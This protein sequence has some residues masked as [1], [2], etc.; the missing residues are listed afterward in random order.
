SHDAGCCQLNSDCPADK[1][2]CRACVGCNLFKWDCCDTGSQ[3]VLAPPTTNPACAGK[4]C[5][6]AA[7]CECTD[8]LACPDGAVPAA[9]QGV[10]V[11]ACDVLRLEASMPPG[12]TGPAAEIV[13][14]RSHARSAR[15][16]LRKTLRTARTMVAR[17]L[18]SGRC[19]RQVVREV[20]VVKRAIPRA[21]RL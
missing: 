15:Q 18:M 10:F 8:K 21:K 7:Y 20:T 17:K 2:V 19:R 5:L 4:T 11:A 14:A 13:L 6:D 1:P 9:L 12:G 16:G 3:C